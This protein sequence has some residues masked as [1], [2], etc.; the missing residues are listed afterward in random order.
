MFPNFTETNPNGTSKTNHLD[1]K[2]IEEKAGR[3]NKNKDKDLH[4]TSRIGVFT[5]KGS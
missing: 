5:K 1:N 3:Q 2:W 4:T